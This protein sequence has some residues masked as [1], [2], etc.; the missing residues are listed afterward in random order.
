MAVSELNARIKAVEKLITVF[1][2][3][4]MVHLGVTLISLV[5]LIGAGVFLFFF[6]ES[7]SK[8]AVLTLMFGS[9][10]LITYSAGRLLKMW[11]QALNMLTAGDGEEGE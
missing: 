4:R 1:K 6:D 5:L 2:L 3:E 11:D 7:V 8:I 9:S 10:G